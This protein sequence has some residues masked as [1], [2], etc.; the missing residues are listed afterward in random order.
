MSRWKV[1]SSRYVLQL[2]WFK[3]RVDRVQTGRGVVLD[4]YP[5]IE[6]RDW[7]CVV[8]V[9]REQE[10]VLVQQYRHGAEQVTLEFVA[11]GVDP[12][13][14]PLAAARRELLEE[15][16]YEADEWQLLRRVSPDTTRHG[17]TV[18]IFL[19]T[20]ARCVA[21]QRLEP[22]EDV[23]VTTRRLADPQLRD[24]LSHAVH[25]LSWYL[26]RD[27]LSGAP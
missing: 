2:P 13:E 10:A 15:T 19:A 12:G 17:N 18:H 25:V 22:A 20:G 26:A 5:I 1:L 27:A 3:L 14:D 9:T 7:V 6:S 21:E 16:G 8:T 11:G 24:E 4:D 23:T